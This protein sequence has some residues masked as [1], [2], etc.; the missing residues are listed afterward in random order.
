MFLKNCW[1]CAGWDYQISQGKTSI[2][3]RKIA[4][5]RVV[6]YRKLNGD[7]V[8]LEDRCPHRQAALSMGAKEGDDLRCMYHG[9]KFGADGKCNEIPGQDNIPERACVRA[10]PVVEKDNWIWVWM[11]DPEKADPALICNSVGPG[12][13]DYIVRPSY[14]QVDADYRMENANLADLSHSSFTHDNTIAMGWAQAL[15]R[16]EHKILPRGIKTDYWVR[17]V[18]VPKFVA[19]L[20]PPGFTCDAHFDITQTVPCNWILHFRVFTAGTATEGESNGELVLDSWSCQAITPRDADSVDYYFSWGVSKATER[21][22]LADL[23]KE[24][25]DAAF[26]EDKV[27][28]EGQRIR[29]QEKPDFKTFDIAADAG[30]G[31]MLWVLDKLIR[32]ERMQEE[33]L[34]ASSL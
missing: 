21:P 28:L 14:I 31:K 6:L 27:M 29:M 3:A 15:A 32:E 30:P 25:I 9:I 11:G 7:V 23:L 16:P 17:N 22:G 5:E 26:F 12:N 34:I 8:A 24:G 13:P 4:G 20:F 18:P 33:A 10:F 1:Y 19:H 2:V